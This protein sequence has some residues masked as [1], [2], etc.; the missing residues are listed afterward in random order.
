M[1]RYGCGAV[2]FCTARLI[3]TRCVSAKLVGKDLDYFTIDFNEEM[4]A[5][6]GSLMLRQTEFVR[7]CVR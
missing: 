1:A 7:A 3:K 6:H 4:S 5:F 2:F